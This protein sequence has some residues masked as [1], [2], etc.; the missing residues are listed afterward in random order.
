MYQKPKEPIIPDDLA[1][2]EE[3]AKLL[4]TSS[5]SVRRWV[6]AGLLPGFKM[7][8]QLRIS[9][10][11]ALAMIERVVPDCDRPRLQTRAEYEAQ[12]R[13]DDEILRRAGVKR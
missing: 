13:A 5:A 12:K 8:G 9:R 10:A 11:D 4:G 6:R 1:T 3:I 7:V 2:P